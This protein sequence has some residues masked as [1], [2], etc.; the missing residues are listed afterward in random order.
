MAETTRRLPKIAP[1]LLAADPLRLAEQVLALGGRADELHVDVMDFTFG[2]GAFGSPRLVRHLRALTD[3]PLTCH[4]MVEAPDRL[5][6]E[7]AEAGAAQVVV[8]AERTRDLRATAAAVRAAG[9]RVGI[10]LLPTTPVEDY[11]D[12]LGEFASLL[13]VTV[14]VPGLGAQERVPGASER[15]A[16]MRA[17]LGRLGLDLEIGTDGGVDLSTIHGD[18]E[19]G[20]TCCVVGTDVFGHAD[21][22]ARV[23]QLRAAC[24]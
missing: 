22:A 10:A 20:A 24:G 14:P 2:Q 5:A 7:F 12:V 21:P 1:S 3:T 4:L 19:A 11:L 18:V 16:Q 13:V 17:T 15:I 9:A 8:H 23:D 6:V